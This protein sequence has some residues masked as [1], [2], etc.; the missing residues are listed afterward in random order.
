MTRKKKWALL[1]VLVI[2]GAL[3]FAPGAFAHYATVT[4][5][6]DCNG[7][8]SYTVSSWEKRSSN[9]GGVNNSVVLKDSLGNT[10]PSPAGQFNDADGYQFSGTFTISTSVTSDTLTPY[11]GT[12][13]DGLAGGL[14]SK[15]ATTVTRPNNCGS[16]TTNASGPATVPASLHDT[17]HL[18]DT[19]QLPRRPWPG[20][21]RRRRMQE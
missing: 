2:G 18:I 6:L 21:L 13:G 7:T 12:W 8:I 9:N 15:Y 14:Y 1:G 4:A 19:A 16:L 5:T 11:T 20:G 10:F 3:A 17:A